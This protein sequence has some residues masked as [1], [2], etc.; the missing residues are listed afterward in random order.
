MNF[1]ALLDKVGMPGGFRR[2]SRQVAAPLLTEPVRFPYG[3]FRFKTTL[4]KGIPFSIQTSADFQN[5]D[6]IAEGS[7]TG[8]ATEY[9]DSQASKFSYRFYRLF[10]G[11]I[12][13]A[14]VIGY[15]TV[16]LPPGFSLIAN[17]FDAMSNAVGDLFKGWP[18]GTT[19]SK[20]DTRFFKLGENRVTGPAW[21]N[22]GEKLMPGEG[23]ILYNPTSDYKSHSFTGKVTQGHSAM[24][25]PSGFSLRSSP[26]AQGGY[27][28]DDLGFPISDGDVIHVF[29]RD[30]QKY[31]LY[32]FEKGAWVAG[33]PALSVGESFWVAKTAAGNWT[34]QLVIGESNNAV[35]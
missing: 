26:V 9:V 31:V 21:T 1:P 19:L 10:A 3:P 20:F 5:W 34:K 16:T 25:I 4:E 35:A 22:P 13:S 28:A 24:P 12:P 7:G 23:A 6:V 17:P 32:P 18:E 2:K 33:Q 14:S 11:D 29:D 8:Q 27:L 15:A 30:Q